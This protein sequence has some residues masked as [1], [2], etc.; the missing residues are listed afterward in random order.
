MWFLL[1]PRAITS[2][3]DRWRGPQ[4]VVPTP[5]QDWRRARVDVVVCARNQ[6]RCIVHCLA[7][8]ARQTV[9]P[10]RLLLVD[11][12]GA[13]RD[14]T[15]QLAR[16]F[17]DANGIDLEIVQRKWSLGRS[18]TLRRQSREFRGDVLFALDGDTVLESPD[19]IE[20]CV[21]ELFQ[22]AGI[23]SACGQ[24]RT[25]GA[26]H[27]RAIADSAPF[28]AWLAGD[29]WV[30]PHARDDRLERVLRWIGDAHR[31]TIALYE[32][33]LVNRGQMDRAGGIARPVGPVAYRRRYLKDLFDRWD[34]V[35]GEDVTDDA[36]QFIGMALAHEGYRN[37]QL[38]DVVARRCGERVG[39]LPALAHR[40]S[41]AFLEGARA[42]DALLRSPIT[43]VRRL[44]AGRARG[45]QGHEQ[46]RVVEAYRQPFGERLTRLHGRPIGTALH[47]SALERVGLPAIALG[48]LLLGHGDVLAVV[49]AIEALVVAALLA[50]LAPEGRL[51]AAFR[52]LLTA[53]L[54]HALM[55]V[56]W[57]ALLR[58]GAMRLARR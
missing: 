4:A 10:E 13:E 39:R 29:H 6:Q 19:Y 56:E 23:A 32:Q 18:V 49:L 2:A 3:V 14:H 25:L 43:R 42:F 34:P 57:A 28:R 45:D 52:G 37:I 54:R 35:R 50:V 31:D 12:G 46:R 44:L 8:L 7:A 5:T 26:P 47:L 58:F 20:R 27:R 41:V 51:A 22:G 38:P 33:R 16:E 24:L 9:K 53:P 40:E 1:G 17:A 36:E 11:D 48:A 21:R 30:D 55:F 15:A